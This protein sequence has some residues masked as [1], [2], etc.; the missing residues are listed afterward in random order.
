MSDSPRELH[1][2]TT[3]K[4]KYKYASADEFIR[5][6]SKD[7]S[8]FGIFVKT[9]SPLK[10]GGPVKLEL[11]QND[12]IPIISGI[13]QVVWRRESA[14]SAEG[15]PG[16]GIKF[17]KLD[18]TSRE[19]VRLAVENRGSAP[20]RFDRL[21]N[22][23]IH[24]TGEIKW[25]LP[26]RIRTLIGIQ[27]TDR[28]NSEIPLPRDSDGTTS[29]RPCSLPEVDP[30]KYALTRE[31]PWPTLTSMQESSVSTD[32]SPQDAELVEI[33]SASA[34]EQVK[35][36]LPGP[37]EQ[38]SVSSYST[39]QVQA[40]QSAVAQV[41]AAAEAPNAA[42]RSAKPVESPLR[43]SNE[44]ASLD[45]SANTFTQFIPQRDG[46]RISRSISS[47]FNFVARIYH[48]GE[49]KPLSEKTSGAKLRERLAAQ[50]V[51]RSSRA[52][53]NDELSPNAD[54]LAELSEVEIRE[55]AGPLEQWARE[56]AEMDESASD[57]IIK[58]FRRSLKFE[59]IAAKITASIRFAV[60]YA[61]TTW[62]QQGHELAIDALIVV[63]LLSGVSALF[64]LVPQAWRAARAPDN[65]KS[66]EEL[67]VAKVESNRNAGQIGLVE[68]LGARPESEQATEPNRSER[69]VLRVVT[70]PDRAVVTVANK[71]FITPGEV[72]IDKPDSV[73]RVTVR[74]KSRQ[75]MERQITAADFIP[76]GDRL[77]HTLNVQLNKLST[78]TSTIPSPIK[79]PSAIHRRKSS[80]HIEG[81]APSVPRLSVDNF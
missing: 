31:K 44:K 69:Y 65:Q 10:E 46:K 42:G 45:S 56:I 48:T 47:A 33:S 8:L 12:G 17:L 57:E 74:K 66:P 70:Q 52:A 27:P 6:A 19:I 35:A 5:E 53:A 36:A 54:R 16:M 25:T 49:F 58:S 37:F 28:L 29:A 41:L 1:S 63:L 32:E 78:K 9:R 23:A 39:E 20:S 11:Q 67:T 61:R 2:S 75:P 50:A 80:F 34:P 73:L 79:P 43:D 51:S 64:V 77:I 7:I 76:D 38:L 68:G 22:T 26:N 81:S 71:S 55:Y 13:G 62:N 40:A 72:E 24:T 21:G 4:I 59:R 30:L 18:Q 3:L 14:Q 15:P 60:A